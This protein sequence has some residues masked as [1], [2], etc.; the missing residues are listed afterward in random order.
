MD[1]EVHIE[2]WSAAAARL[3][4]IQ[5]YNAQNGTV[6]ASCVTA[7]SFFLVT[8]HG[9][10]Q[11]SLSGKVYDARSVHILHGGKETELQITPRGSDF[12]C[13]LIL[14]Q[15]YCESPE[16]R[17][18]LEQSYA[19]TPYTLLPLEEK[20]QTMNRLWQQAAPIDKLQAQSLFLP[21]VYEVM[22]QIRT[23]APEISRP[24]IVTEA[25]HY[26]HE[27]YREPLT[28][29]ALAGMYNCSTSHL[30]RLFKNQLGFGP[31]DYLIHVRIRKAKQL[32][33]KSKARIQEI[34]GSVGY[35]DVYYFSRLFK[36][37]TGCSPLQFRESH[38]QGVQNS[39]S[40]LLKSSIVTDPTFSHNN[41]ENDYQ[42]MK[43]GDTTM[44]RFSR[45]AFAATLLLC[46]TLFLSACQAGSN[47]G[48]ASQPASTNAAA[49]SAAVE[50]RTYKHLKGETEIP[51]KPQRVVSLF[52]LGELMAL[53]VKPVGATNYILNNPLLSDVSGIE[54]VGATPDA[55]KILSLEPD[56][57]VTTAPFAEVVEGGYEA[58]SQIAPTIV[59]EQYNDPFKDVGMFGD[60]LG[61]Q[62]EAKQWT[63]AFTAKLAEYKE[64]ISPLVGADETF[65]ILNVR[66][67]AIYIYGDTNMGG[68]IIYKYLGLKPTDK[69][70]DEVINGETWEISNE[71]IPE[72][73]G[74]RLFLAVNEGAEA[75]LKKVDKLIQNSPAGKAGKIYNID[76]NQFLFSDPI[77]VE[78]Q[79][80][81]IVNLLTG[82]SI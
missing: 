27:H 47:T 43:E 81:I 54:D 24:N 37:H 58:L 38:R 6:P 76:F 72:F 40:R 1:W 66:S 78:Q 46:T 53:G 28:A 2:R 44:F 68:N 20:C 35:G 5:Q 10:A 18:S 16:E 77:S 15:A 55:E 12:T 29:E 36:K 67:E 32:L 80:D 45:P 75:E 8:V 11:V 22:R 49:D 42:W 52:H 33:L 48:A 71:V 23:S 14:Y 13:Y 31:I 21:F 64:K 50:M 25:I 39:P 63:E 79:L 19:F 30:F 59:V 41:N 65:S 74:D 26:I 57:I 34:A 61:K 17:E 73:I 62:E 51:V 82:S 56:L 9:V 60:I 70:K 69:V 7:S 3:L 4:N